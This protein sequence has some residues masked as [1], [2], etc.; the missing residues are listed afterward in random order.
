M[1]QG[2]HSLRTS[3]G[4]QTVSVRNIG[5]SLRHLCWM[6]RG[7]AEIASELRVHNIAITNNGFQNV[8]WQ[9]R[10]IRQK[11]CTQIDECPVPVVYRRF[12][13]PSPHELH[14]GSGRHCR[15]R[16]KS[17]LASRSAQSLLVK[18]RFTWEL[19]TG[20]ENFNSLAGL[21]NHGL[22]AFSSKKPLHMGVATAAE[23]SDYRQA[24]PTTFRT[25]SIPT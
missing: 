18:T 22:I 11:G 14:M 1:C 13:P 21:T 3:H 24:R 17:S 19:Q 8:N 20:T 2:G 15:N 23:Q 25:L 10:W 5:G 7:Q 16:T 6:W 9:Q 12:S 4:E